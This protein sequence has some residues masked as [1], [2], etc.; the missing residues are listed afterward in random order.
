MSNNID[1][2]ISK[3]RTKNRAR[4]VGSFEGRGGEKK[5]DKPMTSKRSGDPILPVLDPNRNPLAW[6]GSTQPGKPQERTQC[7]T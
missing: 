3:V 1:D 5:I 6:P 2:D 4:V 7:R